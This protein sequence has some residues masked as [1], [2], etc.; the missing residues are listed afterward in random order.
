MHNMDR[1]N[2][3]ILNATGLLV[4]VGLI[5]ILAF[6]TWALVY[7][8]IPDR[9]EASLIQLIGILSGS[10]VVLVSFFYG[11]SVGNKNKDETNNKLADLAQQAQAAALPP[12][13]TV[14]LAPNDSV[15]I[16]GSND[17]DTRAAAKPAKPASR[18]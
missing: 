14:P 16:V 8:E 18:R 15:T 13:N 1:W 4:A 11:N 3:V 17:T 7:V 9:N 2:R 10:I 6:V 5:G 12:S